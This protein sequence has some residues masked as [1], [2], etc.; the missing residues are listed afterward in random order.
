MFLFFQRS[1][2][3]DRL[4]RLLQSDIERANG[5]GLDYLREQLTFKNRRDFRL[6]TAIGIL[7]RF[8]VIEGDLASKSLRLINIIPPELV[9]Q[10]YLDR[11]LKNEQ[12]KLYQMVLYT[13]EK[14]CRKAFIHKY[15]GLKYRDICNT[16][17]VDKQ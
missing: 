14:N 16:C 4:Y 11:K 9:N 17:D 2:F 5:E 15:F 12:N 1:G 13:K 10:N 3:Y 8:G 6:E 7:D